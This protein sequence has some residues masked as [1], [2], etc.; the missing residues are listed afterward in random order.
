MER[1]PEAQHANTT[2]FVCKLYKSGTRGI[3]DFDNKTS[4]TKMLIHIKPLIC[5]KCNVNNFKLLY[6]N[7]I[8]SNSDDNIKKV[9]IIDY[10]ILVI[11]PDYMYSIPESI[12]YNNVSKQKSSRI[13]YLIKLDAIKKI[14]K[15]LRSA[16]MKECPCCYEKC[17]ITTKY[18]TCDHIICEDC[19]NKWNIRND[20]CP[21]C[22]EPV[23]ENYRRRRE[24]LE[25]TDF[26][27]IFRDNININ[28]E[29]ELFVRE[30]NM[31]NSP[32]STHTTSTGE[33][34][35]NI[36]P[37][38]DNNN[39]VLYSY[40]N[41]RMHN[42]ISDMIQEDVINQNIINNNYDN[43]N[44]IWRLLMRARRSVRQRGIVPQTNF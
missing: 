42:I 25:L 11:K 15:F 39:G 22:R 6:N 31:I 12:F 33:R 43:S 18:Y 13:S 29:R 17:I 4:I 30:R 41:N 14:Q 27:N 26:W 36:F 35:L 16:N 44:D 10:I 21:T 7:N 40:T 1:W 24:N 5:E 23:K 3:Y 38:N 19:F 8:I 20:N 34:T 9:F 2:R 32:S 28:N 37:E